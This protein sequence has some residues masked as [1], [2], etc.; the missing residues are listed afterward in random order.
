M[1]RRFSAVLQILVFKYEQNIVLRKI[2]TELEQ[3]IKKTRELHRT[4]YVLA[5]WRVSG[6]GGI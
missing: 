3:F 2:Y 5:L 1:R 4:V 6:G